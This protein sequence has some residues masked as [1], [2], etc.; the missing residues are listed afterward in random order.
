ME[1]NQTVK[2]RLES[3]YEREDPTAEA[4]WWTVLVPDSCWSSSCN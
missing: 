2:D 1:T 3:M 4:R